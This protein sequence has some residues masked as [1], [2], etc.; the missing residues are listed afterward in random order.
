MPTADPR[1]VG[2]AGQ[3]RRTT[4]VPPGGT[5]T[6]MVEPDLDSVAT[7][8]PVGSRAHT[9][10]VPGPGRARPAR[11][12]VAAPR[13]RPRGGGEQ[14]AGP[15]PAGGGGGEGGGGAAPGAGVPAAPAAPQAFTGPCA[16]RPVHSRVATERAGLGLDQ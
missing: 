13:A 16:V 14:H 11:P 5:V 6:R 9:V 3:A 10:A 12:A 4:T 1:A 8:R 2:C 15:R 7:V